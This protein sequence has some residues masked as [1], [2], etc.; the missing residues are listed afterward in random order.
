MLV[1][2]DGTVEDF[3]YRKCLQHALEL[4]APQKAKTYKWL[5]G[6][7]RG[8]TASSLQNEVK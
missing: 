4:I 1:R 5:N 6:A 8:P 2:T 7:S 3:S